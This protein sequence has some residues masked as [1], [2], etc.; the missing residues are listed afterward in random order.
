MKPKHTPG[1]WVVD[2]D[3]DGCHVTFN[4]GPSVW[5]TT[6]DN[7]NSIAEVNELRANARLIAAAPALLARLEEFRKMFAFSPDGQIIQRP[8]DLHDWL[9]SVD[10]TITKAT[11]KHDLEVTT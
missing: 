3:G 11:G 7:D 6:E 8:R 2:W 5:D 10:Q 1:T 9:L 4:E